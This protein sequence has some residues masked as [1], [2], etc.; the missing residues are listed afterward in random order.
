MRTFGGSGAALLS[1]APE[2]CQTI[3]TQASARG[4]LTIWHAPPGLVLA[5][6]WYWSWRPMALAARGSR[7][8]SPPG[9]PPLLEISCRAARFVSREDDMRQ[10]RGVRRV[11][12]LAAA[13]ARQR[14]RVCHEKEAGLKRTHVHIYAHVHISSIVLPR[15]IEHANTRPSSLICTLYCRT[16]RLSTKRK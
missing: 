11:G 5:Q 13:R 15:G 3:E 10:V 14:Q 16:C 12:R 6:G 4:W 9:S 8:L 1:R 2:P 7:T